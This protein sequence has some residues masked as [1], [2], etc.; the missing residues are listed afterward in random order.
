MARS[1]FFNCDEP[2]FETVLALCEFS[3]HVGD[4]G[5]RVESSIL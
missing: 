3:A 4:N 2:R 1:V 5:D